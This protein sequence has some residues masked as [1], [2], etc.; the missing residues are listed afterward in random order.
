MYF[1]GLCF[2]TFHLFLQVSNKIK[3]LVLKRCTRLTRTPDFSGCLCLERLS[4]FQCSNIQVID[5]PIGKLKQ[6]KVLTIADCSIRKLPTIIGELE[7]LE[8]LN[9]IDCERLEGELPLEIGKLS[10]LKILHLSNTRICAVF[11]TIN[12][13]IHLEQLDLVYL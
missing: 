6:L 7:N 8:K 4:L 12:L 13:L 2:L 1:F 11:S 3:V 9:V 5:S 10:F